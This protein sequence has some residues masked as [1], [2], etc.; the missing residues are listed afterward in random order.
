M[1]FFLLF[2]DEYFKFTWL[3]DWSYPFYIKNAPSHE[4][5]AQNVKILKDCSKLLC[6]KD[7]DDEVLAKAI[8]P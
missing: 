5:H 6:N 1:D 4:W 7:Y 2:E 8:L 3:H